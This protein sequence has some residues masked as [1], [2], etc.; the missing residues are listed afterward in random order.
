MLFSI[1]LDIYY[2]YPLAYKETMQYLVKDKFLFICSS[3]LTFS[4]AMQL[5]FYKINSLAYSFVLLHSSERAME[6]EKFRAKQG[7]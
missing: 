1:T 5:A 7:M 3:G 2:T 4:S 6:M